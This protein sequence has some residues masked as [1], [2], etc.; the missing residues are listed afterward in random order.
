MGC[1]IAAGDVT[2][3]IMNPFSTPEQAYEAAIIRGSARADI[4]FEVVVDTTSDLNYN[5]VAKLRNAE[6]QVADLK[7]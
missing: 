6:I 7:T 5:L 3:R 4:D 2:L 1:S